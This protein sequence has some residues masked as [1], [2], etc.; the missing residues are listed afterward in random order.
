M[1][2]HI[3]VADDDAVMVRL[4][5]FNLKKAG[6]TYTTC[7]DGLSIENNV[8]TTKPDLAIIDFMLPGKTGLEVIKEFKADPELVKIPIVVVTGQGK[9]SK[10]TELLDAGASN[11]FTKPFSPTA[12]MEYVR[13]LLGKTE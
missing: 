13:S 12:L 2:K 11:V 10:K 3:L 5:E 1:K 4:L 6:F 9:G 7:R 8:R